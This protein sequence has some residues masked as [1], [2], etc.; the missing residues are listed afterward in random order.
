MELID[1]AK[2]RTDRAAQFRFEPSSVAGFDSEA[3]YRILA[4]G[5]EGFVLGNGDNGGNNARIRPEAPD[6]LNRGQYWQVKMLDLNRRV[7][8]GAFY[9]QNFDDGGGNAKVDYLLQWPAEE[10]KWNNAQF[11]FLPV[12]GE[13]GTWQI[14]SAAPA[15]QGKVYAVKDGQPQAHRSCRSRPRVVVCLRTGGETENPVALLGGR[16]PLCREQGGRTCHLH[17]LPSERAMTDDAA[18]YATPWV[19]PQSASVQ[20]LDGTWKFNL[21]SEPSQRP[22]DFYKMDY[23]V[24]KWDDIPVPSN[25]EMQGYDRPIYCNVEYPHSNTPPYIKARPGFN[26][27]GKNY[28]IN[29]VGS[30]VRVF[31]LK[32]PNRPGDRTYIHFGGIYSAAFVYVN[33]HY[34][35]YSQGSNNVAEFDITDYVRTGAN[36]L[37][38]QV[39]R[40]SDGSYLECQDM[41]RMSGIFRSVYLYA[42]RK[43]PCATI[44]S[45]AA[46]TRLRATAAVR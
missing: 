18:F 1:K 46:S 17:A 9:D 31:E 2:A 12:E 3:T 28:G 15:K 35:G 20:C 5:T 27:G 11:V 24:S 37:A 21:V 14:A 23:D 19:A 45:P 44:T 33:G 13:P 22:V 40:W 25:W 8:S 6:S 34:V 16:D 26:D 39:L 41:F 42:P 38:V 32:A 7:V 43:P 36:R 4:L 29:P 30:Y 10:G